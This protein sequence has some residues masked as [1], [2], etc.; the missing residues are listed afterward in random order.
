MIL[1]TATAVAV[2]GLN[3]SSSVREIISQKRQ[4]CFECNA[5]L[6]IFSLVKDFIKP[7]NLHS[8]AF[9]M[10]LVL[11]AILSHVPK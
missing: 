7:K 8:A 2:V 1:A 3:F 10:N 11:A 9:A 6:L 5:M 4:M